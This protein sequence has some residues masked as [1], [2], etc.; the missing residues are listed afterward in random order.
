MIGVESDEN[1]K[2]L[3][4]DANNLYGWAMSQPLPT[5]EFEKLSFNPKNYT[6]DYK[7]EQLVEDLVQTPDDKE[8]GFF[9][10]SDL[11]YSAEN[12]EKNRNLSIF[13]LTNKSRS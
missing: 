11:D 3:Y 5:G 12:K 9:I 13:S 2:L 4:I 1:N 8:Y 6:D 7:L 10:E